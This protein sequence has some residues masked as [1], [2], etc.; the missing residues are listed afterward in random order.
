MLT[1][2]SWRDKLFRGI[3]A[4]GEEEKPPAL[5]T[6]AQAHTHTHTRT[7]THTHTRQPNYR[8]ILFS[9]VVFSF[10]ANCSIPP[11]LFIPPHKAHTHTHTPLSSSSSI[12]F[13]P[14]LSLLL[15]SPFFSAC[16]LCRRVT[17]PS[18]LSSIPLQ[19]PFLLAPSFHS[20][21]L[22]CSLTLSL[23]SV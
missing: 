13:Y 12:V 4:A 7:H 2:Q 1:L 16:H 23:H 21:P 22:S 18:S 9:C 17:P 6:P 15:L 5:R 14:L 20:Q 11:S 10:L 3:L 8:P 19:L